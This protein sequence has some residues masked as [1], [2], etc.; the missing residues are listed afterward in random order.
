[1]RNRGTRPQTPLLAALAV[2]CALSQAPQAELPVMTFDEVQAGMKGQGRTVFKGTEIETFEVEILGKLPN[3]GPDQNLI[4]ALCTGGPLAHTGVMAGMSGSPVVIDGKLIGAIAY[5]WGFTKDAI[6][7]ITPIEEMLAIPKRESDR[8]V[9]T[10]TRVEPGGLERLNEPE[11]LDTFF[12]SLFQRSMQ[13]TGTPLPTMVPLAVSGIRA[14]ALTRGLPSLTAAGF[15][16][17]QSGGGGGD[18]APSPPL[19]PG[20]AVGLK[21]VRGDIEMT[22][23]GT[24]TWTRDDEVLAFGH[25]LFGLG[26]TDLPLTGATVQALLPSLE[27]SSKIAT[28]LAE[29]GALRQ[30]RTSGIYGRIG[31]SARMIP[32]RLKVSGS[33]SERTFSFDVADDP[34]LSPLL[35]YISLRGVLDSRERTFGNVS[36]RLREGSV[37]KMASGVDVALD[38]LFSGPNAM[39]MGTAI[40]AYILHLLM[41]NAWEQPQIAGVNLILDFDERPQTARIRRASLSRYRVHPGETVRVTVVLQPYRGAQRVLTRDV[42]IPPE[43]PPGVLTL[44]VTGAMAAMQSESRGERAV[45]QTLDQLI[46]LINRL[47]RNDQLYI[48]ATREDSG[49]ML[50]GSRLPS[51]PPSVARVLSR[52]RT[53]GNL[54]IVSRRAILEEMIDTDYLIEGAAKLRLEVEA[55]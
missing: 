27:Q 45:P 23:T 50:E 42:V 43:T 34:L 48:M 16:P 8:R 26:A 40:S 15:L 51:L 21:L 19:E 47:R 41:N 17:M 32:I 49:V 36:I 1:M 3:I 55:P 12:A 46:R 20:S 5:S 52:P 24:V 11:L 10:A 9:T 30:D 13:R 33:E 6:A 25:P 39:T 53:R 31:V 4:L 44:G 35:L 7:G 22:A 14:D 38:N 37:I 18:P 29:V 28:P 54:T 2:A